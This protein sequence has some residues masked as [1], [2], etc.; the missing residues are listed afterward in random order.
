MI[1]YDRKWCKNCKLCH[2]KVPATEPKVGGSSPSGYTNII[3]DA[4]RLSSI[5]YCKP[6]KQPK[7]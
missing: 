7:N 2:L 4:T 3:Q 5:F 1:K 6:K